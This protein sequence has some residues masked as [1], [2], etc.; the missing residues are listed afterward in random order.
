MTR[1]RGAAAAAVVGITLAAVSQSHG[2]HQVLTHVAAAMQQPGT[3]STSP[4]ANKALADRMAAAAGWDS[5]EIGCLNEVWQRESGFRV[6]VWNYQGADAYGIPQANPADKMASAGPDWRT[7]PAT[8]IKW[9]LGYIK[10]LYGSPCGAWS[11]EK[12]HGWY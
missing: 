2:G 7:D 12:S 1:L 11:H 5:R 8:Q 10:D 3:S 6:T 4:A 9:G